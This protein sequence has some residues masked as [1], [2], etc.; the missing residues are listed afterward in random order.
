M[1]TPEDD[2]VRTGREERVQ[3]L[4]QSAIH[5]WALKRSSLNQRHEA[6]AN[7]CLH[8]DTVREILD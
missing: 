4:L 3:A 2:Y 6:R 8:R 7:L 1:C 5:F